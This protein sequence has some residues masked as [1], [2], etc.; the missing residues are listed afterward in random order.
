MCSVLLP[1]Q[2]LSNSYMPRCLRNAA[3]LENSTYEQILSHLEKEINLNNLEAPDE[4]QMKT[5]R[6]HS[7]KPNLE[8][9]KLTS[10][11]RKKPDHYRNQ[12]DQ[13]ERKKANQRHQKK[14]WQF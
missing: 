6:P 10:H 3:H 2:S 5:L 9:P 13:L 12:P 8:K 4:L 7:S 1:T 11:H 14:C